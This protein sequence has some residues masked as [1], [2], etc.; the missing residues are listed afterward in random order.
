VIK[1]VG[2]PM[3]STHAAICPDCGM[4][5][6]VCPDCEMIRHGT[7]QN[8]CGS[9]RACTYRQTLHALLRTLHLPVQQ[10][11]TNSG[12]YVRQQQHADR[13]VIEAAGVSGLSF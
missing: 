9:E 1:K 3:I 13:L 7:T 12:H 5:H 11:Q 6:G 4:A 2:K 8:K 10:Y